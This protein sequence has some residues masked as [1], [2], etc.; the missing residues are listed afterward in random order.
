MLLPLYSISVIDME[1]FMHLKA[2]ARV[3]AGKISRFKHT[4]HANIFR[5]FYLQSVLNTVLN[6]KSNSQNKTKYST[7]QVIVK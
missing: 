2:F 6:R 1:C 7:L 3:T 4:K 5:P